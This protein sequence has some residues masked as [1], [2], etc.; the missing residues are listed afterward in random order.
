[1]QLAVAL[2]HSDFERNDEHTLR[3]LGPEA[4]VDF[5]QWPCSGRY[6]E[7]RGY[8][9]GKAVEI[10]VRPER[11]GTVRQRARL[12]RMQIDDVEVGRVG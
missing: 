8:A 4:R 3:S 10:I 1:M 5:I 6:A 2:A 12:C 7:R 11:L 9:V